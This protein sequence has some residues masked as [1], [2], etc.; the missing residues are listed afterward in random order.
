MS[1]VLDDAEFKKQKARIGKFL[2]KWQGPMGLRWFNIEVIFD[3]SYAQDNSAAV[4]SMARWR[5]R[6]FDI[7]FYIPALMDKTDA[8][9]EKTVVHELSHCLL[10]PI[11][12]N[13]RDVDENSEYRRDLMEF[14]TEL[15]TA[16]LMWCRDEGVDDH[17]AELK[18]AESKK[19]KDKEKENV[20]TNK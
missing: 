15:V 7:T 5:Y 8:E 11:S 19:V 16:A 6:E 2:T 17:K 14:N 4:T 12:C 9:V 18:A 20:G 1:T 10:A 13:M 3:R